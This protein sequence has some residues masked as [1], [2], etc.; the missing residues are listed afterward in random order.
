[1]SNAANDGV[2]RGINSTGVLVS[3]WYL[4]NPPVG[5]YDI[6]V[7]MS[8]SITDSGGI[9]AEYQNVNQ[10]TPFGGD[11]QRSRPGGSASD[12]DR[13]IRGLAV[14]GGMAIDVRDGP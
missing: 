10:T 11:V 1:M 3:L 13:C 8:G 9:G 7:T 5:T 4:V 6:A 12:V 2:V 14:S